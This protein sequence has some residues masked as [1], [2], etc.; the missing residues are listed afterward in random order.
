MSSSLI[1]VLAPAT[2]RLSQF[3]GTMSEA[4]K[5]KGIPGNPGGG[6]GRSHSSA[7]AVQTAA[8]TAIKTNKIT[9]GICAMVLLLSTH[10][11]NFTSISFTRLFLIKLCFN[12]INHSIE[13][14]RFEI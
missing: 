2:L 6:P 7:A 8:S 12:N 11:D 14:K 13:L 10:D 5:K 4:L 3:K 1:S 9:V